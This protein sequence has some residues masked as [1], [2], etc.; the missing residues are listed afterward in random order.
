MVDP[1][2]PAP[3]SDDERSADDRVDE[4]IAAALTAI[5]GAPL[6]TAPGPARRAGWVIRAIRE[7]GT[8]R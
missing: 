4:A 3:R 8:D 6:P 1:S 5:D 2:A 7:H